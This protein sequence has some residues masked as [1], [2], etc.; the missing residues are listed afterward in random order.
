MFFTILLTTFLALSAFLCLVIL[1]YRLWEGPARAPWL[2]V[3]MSIFTWIP[4]VFGI[5]AG[6]WLGL[7]AVLLGQLLLLEAFMFLHQ[8]ASGYRG[9][10]LMETQN[11][12]GGFWGNQG[13]LLL[14]IPALP[15][16][17]VLR[18]GEYILYPPLVWSLNFPRL[19]HSEWVTVSRQK[20]ENLVGPDLVWCLYCDWMT[21]LYSLGAEMLRNI[22]SFWCPIKFY[23]GKKC[24]N[25]RID[26]PDIDQ[27]VDADGTIEEVTALIEEK[28]PR[29]KDAPRGWFGSKE[30]QEKCGPCAD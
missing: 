15:L 22:E 3:V 12:I 26:F 14:T 17:L 21:G 24:E 30:R 29:G 27:W 10:T 19:K 1:I 9:P 7:L 23:D 4:W 5:M 11:R 16:F 28:Y 13:G 6:G 18:A 20:F 2:D 8:K 25:C